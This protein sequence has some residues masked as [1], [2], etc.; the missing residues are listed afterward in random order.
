[1]EAVL[2]TGL[3]GLNVF[4]FFAW[5]VAIFGPLFGL[6]FVFLLNLSPILFQGISS[7]DSALELRDHGKSVRGFAWDVRLNRSHYT[8][9]PRLLSAF[10]GWRRESAMLREFF[11]EVSSGKRAIQFSL[12]KQV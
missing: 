7:N 5:A 8:P 10:R 2:Y 3:I 9:L 1:M 4:L 6:G 11:G 12:L